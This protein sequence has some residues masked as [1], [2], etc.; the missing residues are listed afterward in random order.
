MSARTPPNTRLAEMSAGVTLPAIEAAI[1]NCGIGTRA[2][3]VL[4]RDTDAELRTRLDR[5]KRDD[6]QAVAEVLAVA[7]R[8]AA[9]LVAFI[10]SAQARLRAAGVPGARQ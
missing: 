7:Q 4:L 3:F 5:A 10:E 9:G 8:S 2:A 1:Q 6:M